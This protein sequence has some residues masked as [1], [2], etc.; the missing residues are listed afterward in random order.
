MAKARNGSLLSGEDSL[1][2]PV[3]PAPVGQYRFAQMIPMLLVDVAIPI[4][5][6]NLLAH[7]GVST[8][9]A[10]AA[11][12]LSPALNNIRIWMKSRRLEPLGII[13]MSLLAVST[14]ASLISG[15]VFFALIKE[16]FLTGVFG[17]ICLASLF[18][19]RPLLFYIVRQFVAG[20]DPERIA[21]WNGLWQYADFRRATRFVTAVWGIAYVAE[22]LV[23]V[24]FAMTLT[25]AQVVTIS[26]IMA[27]GILFLLIAWTRRHL[28]AVRERRLR[29]QT[30]AAGTSGH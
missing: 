15:S 3:A 8:L 24:V 20:D 21:W 22:A 26:P 6:F 4:A 19:K 13:V 16:S 5:V 7:Y 25:P 29:Q 14:A 18:A 12:G 17:V 11:G 30:T 23:R 9:W 2:K 1:T 28:L 27:F 10:L